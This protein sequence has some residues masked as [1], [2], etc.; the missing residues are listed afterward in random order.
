MDTTYYLGIDIGKYHH[1]AILC[2]KDAKPIAPSLRFQTTIDGF[3][4]LFSYLKKYLSDEDY[5]TVHAGFE[6]TGIY[7]LTVYEQL[8]K[9]KIRM[10]VLN[11]MQVKAYRNEGIRGAKTDRLDAHLSVKVLRFGDYRD[12]DIP[13]EDLF[14]LR[15]LTRLRA[16][17]VDM[18]SGIKLKVIGILDQ[19]FPEY[20]NI[21]PDIFG[22]GSK[23]LLQKALV[24]EAIAAIPTRK[25]TQL[26]RKASRGR[27][28]V[29]QAEGVKKAAEQTIGITLGIDAFSLSLEILLAQIIHSEKQVEKLEREIKKRTAVRAET[30]TSIPGI[31][32]VQEATILAEIGDFERFRNDKNGAEKL[33]A[34]AGIDPKVKESGKYK[35]QATMSKR[36]SPY[37]RR[38]IRQSAF[39]ASLG[40]GKDP[41]FSKI[42][43]KKIA[44]GKRFAVALSHV[45]NKMLHVIYS[46]LKSKK[47]YKPN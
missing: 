42:Y 28:G 47:E 37:L 11:P 45:E 41:M 5:A 36:G 7:W 18:A 32:T 26:L 15:Q 22:N 6:A 10:S 17:L 19:V 35:G 33:V 46:L 4:E 29:K 2:N 39:I 38:T 30:L 25:L 43:E 40:K 9:Q 16:D 24:P 13:P 14:A 21:F 44:K 27:Y 31:G 3:N 12:S 8:Q 23:A 20:S 34:I 1:Q